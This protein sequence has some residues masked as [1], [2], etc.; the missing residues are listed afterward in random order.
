MSYTV[1]FPDITDYDDR[2]QW[3]KKHCKSFES[4]DYA[5]CLGEN[6]VIYDFYFSDEKDAMW[7]KLKW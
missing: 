3:A 4:T 1:S 2:Y 5:D 7:F 6:D